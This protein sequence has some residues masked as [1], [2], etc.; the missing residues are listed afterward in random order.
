MSRVRLQ[1]FSDSLFSISPISDPSL[2]IQ[3]LVYLI[4]DLG[5]VSCRKGSFFVRVKVL[6]FRLC[7]EIGGKGAYIWKIKYPRYKTSRRTA[8]P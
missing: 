5:G 3:F 7:N 6:L 2:D 4:S 1:I 8:T